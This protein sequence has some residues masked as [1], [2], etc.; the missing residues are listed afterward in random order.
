MSTPSASDIAIPGVKPLTLAT[1][2]RG[3]GSLQTLKTCY[4]ETGDLR[5]IGVDEA[6]RGPLFGRLYVGAAI[7]P[8]GPE[9]RHDLM[10]DSKK[11]S[12]K[13][14]RKEVAE[15]IKTNAIAWSV[16]FMDADIIDEINI[17][18]AVLRS[19]HNAI[20]DVMK[21][22]GSDYTDT[23][24]L[25]DGNDFRP[26]TSFDE[27]T[28][29]LHTIPHQTIEGGDNKYTSIAAASILAKVAHDEYIEDMCLAHPELITR[30]GLDKNMGYGTKQH[31]NGILEHG[32]TK[33]HRRTYGRC[34]EAAV[35][36]VLDPPLDEHLI[37]EEL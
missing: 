23:L 26:L 4:N 3:F 9:F 33:W 16:Q 14:K 15:Y 1:L 10:K 31:L 32:I 12:S 11:F 35:S 24:L 7:L 13:K 28:E 5:E 2:R 8:K 25:I 29:E 20:R 30:Y 27:N 21:K 19:M 37:L 34:R 6:G 17:R 36:M 22:I 18:Q